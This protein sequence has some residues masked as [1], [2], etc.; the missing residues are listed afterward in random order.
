MTGERPITNVVER[1]LESDL[2][3]SKVAL[4]FADD[5]ER[6]LAAI[7]P[8][9]YDGL[10]EKTVADLQR[11]IEKVRQGAVN[12]GHLLEVQDVVAQPEYAEKSQPTP[13][14]RR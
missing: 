5:V 3:D 7:D 9:N 14:L 11:Q 4:Q 2:T 6:T 8:S 12:Q 1:F 10:D 13:Q